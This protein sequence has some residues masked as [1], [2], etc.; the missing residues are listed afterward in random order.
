MFGDRQK[1][2][3]KAASN[4]IPQ[5][6]NDRQR[7]CRKTLPNVD[8]G[9]VSNGSMELSCKQQ[10]PMAAGDEHFSSPSLLIEASGQPYYVFCTVMRLETGNILDNSRN[11]GGHCFLEG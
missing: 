11:L 1:R 4:K 2:L 8:L 7:G 3:A 5:A 10:R 6:S 9:P